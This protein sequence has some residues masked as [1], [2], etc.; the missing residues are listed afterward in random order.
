ML[1][2][3]IIESDHSILQVHIFGLKKKFIFQMEHHDINIQFLCLGIWLIMQAHIP[4]AY[5][6]TISTYI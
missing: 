4:R 3:S 2:G 5:I 1:K 6:I